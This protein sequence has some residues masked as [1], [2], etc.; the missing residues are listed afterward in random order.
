MINLL[1][2]VGNV[3][4]WVIRLEKGWKLFDLDAREFLISRDVTFFED[5]FPF[6]H[7]DKANI[8]PNVI[9]PSCND[10][11]DDFAP[12]LDPDTSLELNPQPPSSL[13]PNTEP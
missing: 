6:I 3:F 7:L 4:L 13:G 12:I 11:H 1:A 2:K 10:I 8:T 5:I 9:V